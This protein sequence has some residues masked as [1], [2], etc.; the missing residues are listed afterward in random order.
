MLPTPVPYSSHENEGSQESKSSHP[1]ENEKQ[2]TAD[3]VG[4]ITILLKL[5]L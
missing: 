5:Y 4:R 1:K 3:T 2:I